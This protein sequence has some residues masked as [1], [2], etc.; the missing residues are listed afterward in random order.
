MDEAVSGGTCPYTIPLPYE[1][2][3]VMRFAGDEGQK[4]VNNAEKEG[5]SETILRD[6][7]ESKMGEIAMS[8]QIESMRN[9]IK[10]NLGS[11]G[12]CRA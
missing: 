7:D 11:A 5:F 1:V 6:D 3:N 12:T 10:K 9:L 4:E 8:I 2:Y